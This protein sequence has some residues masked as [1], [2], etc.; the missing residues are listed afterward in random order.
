MNFYKNNDMIATIKIVLMDM[1]LTSNVRYEVDEFHTGKPK[2]GSF[3][4]IFISLKY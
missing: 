1:Y 4:Y 2:F 3:W